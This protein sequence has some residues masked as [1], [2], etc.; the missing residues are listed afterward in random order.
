MS[1]GFTWILAGGGI[2]SAYR[3]ILASVAGALTLLIITRT[4]MNDPFFM[5]L[6]RSQAELLASASASLSE[7]DAVK[8]SVMEYL[9]SPEKVAEL[10]LFISLR[11]AVLVSCFFMFFINRQAALIIALI[12][13]RGR[14]ASFLPLTDFHVPSFTIWVLSLSFPVILLSRL[15]NLEFTEI[16]AWNILIICAI[17]F[18]AQGGG[19]ALFTLTRRAMPP[20]LRL[21]G[22]FLIILVIF[23]PGINALALAALVLLGIAENWLPLRAV[24]T[25]GPA[26]TPGP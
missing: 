4:S 8:R 12:F 17:L 19:I 18:L 5:A 24:K 20:F 15:V 3:F 22:N 11:G 10:I 9:L 25:D 2:R 7:A 16:A 14:P 13:R 23:S 6:I 21:L 26:S 1:L